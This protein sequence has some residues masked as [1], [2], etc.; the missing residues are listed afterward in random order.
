MSASRGRCEVLGNFHH[1]GGNRRG[2]I[3][4]CGPCV[5]R[6]TWSHLCSTTTLSNASYF[7]KLKPSQAFVTTWDNRL[8]TD[9]RKIYDL[10]VVRAIFAGISWQCELPE[11]ESYLRHSN[12]PSGL[13]GV[14]LI[15]AHYMTWR[16]GVFVNR[17]P[18]RNLS[19]IA[20]DYHESGLDWRNLLVSFKFSSTGRYSTGF[21]AVVPREAT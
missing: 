6:L 12:K 2:I 3:R 9:S 19:Q 1:K 18:H 11:R 7:R 20:G 10:G 4:A 8:L 13:Y 21:T 16:L 5:A 17:Y 14:R 15:E